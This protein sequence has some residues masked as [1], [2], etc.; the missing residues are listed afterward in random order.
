MGGQTQEGLSQNWL[1]PEA[2]IDFIEELHHIG[3]N[4]GMAEYI[5]AQ[6][7]LLM[8][9]ARGES[10]QEPQRAASLLGPLLCSSPAEQ[11][12]F[13]EH[14]ERWGQRRRT[15]LSSQPI[16]HE[17]TMAEALDETAK[18]GLRREWILFFGVVVALLFFSWLINNDNE[19]PVPTPIFTP[20]G[21]A[22]PPISDETKTLLEIAGMAILMLGGA[23]LI[24]AAIWRGNANQ[25]LQRRQGGGTADIK[26]IS[27]TVSDQALF[28]SLTFLSLARLFRQR[29][30]VVSRELNVVRTVEHSVEQGGW[31]NPIYDRLLIPP[32]Y[33]VLVDRRSRFDHLAEFVEEMVKRLE[34]HG[35][36]ITP[37]V[38]DGDP[39]LCFPLHGKDA[40]QSL[41]ELAARYEN[42]RLII[43]S[44]AQGLLN[45]VS[46]R[47][48]P[49]SRLFN[50][51][52]YRSVLTPESPANWGATEHELQ[53]EF[54]VLPGTADGLAAFMRIIQGQEKVGE[55]NAWADSAIPTI[56]Q[57]RPQRWIERDAP[58][59]SQIDSLLEEL[60]TYLSE[61]G[62][63]WF[64]ACAVYPELHWQ[65]TITLGQLLKDANGSP[66][67]EPNRMIGLARLPWFRYGTMPDWLRVRL[68]LD[69]PPDQEEEVRTVLEALL[70]TAVQGHGE[71]L[72]LEIAY[73][74]RDWTSR[75]A[76]PL[77][78]LLRREVLPDS[79]IQDHV[80]L[81]FMLQR[82]N[83]AVRVPETL[84]RQL[85]T[86]AGN[87]F[88]WK[89]M[90]QWT[91]TNLIAV[92]PMILTD[93]YFPF[94]A[95]F[96]AGQS[97]NSTE[98]LAIFLL[99]GGFLGSLLGFMQWLVL[100]RSW[101]LNGWPWIGATTIAFVAIRLSTYS[102]LQAGPLGV[103]QDAWFGLFS[104]SVLGLAHTSV[105]FWHRVIAS[106]RWLYTT[107]LVGLINFIWV[108][109][110]SIN[111]MTTISFSVVI[112]LGGGLVYS[113]ITGWTLLSLYR[114][115]TISET[116]SL[117]PTWVLAVSLGFSFGFLITAVTANLITSA[118]PNDIGIGFFEGVIWAFPFVLAQW[119]V[120]RNYR[121][122]KAKHWF[123]LTLILTIAG[124][125][126]LLQL[127]GSETPDSPSF[128]LVFT[129]VGIG[130]GIF[131][132]VAQ[133]IIWY[134]NGLQP[135]QLL[136]WLLCSTAGLAI[137]VGLFGW[138]ISSL[139]SF[140]DFVGVDITSGQVVILDLVIF[141]LLLP[142]SLYGLI[143]AL[144]L[145]PLLHEAV[146]HQST[147]KESATKM[148]R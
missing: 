57:E 58:P 139:Q 75:L 1:T 79:P 110:L 113:L 94:S 116:Y 18:R 123:W 108:L 65:I 102:L 53:R 130:M 32:E 6:D 143:T 26:Q 62:Y 61:D 17:E 67:L 72:D 127:I 24:W 100:R 23:S 8:L 76:R 146:R 42:M 117:R 43:F 46:G 30:Q 38:F 115:A 51:W 64:E 40:P 73:E 85:F 105:L 120:L 99:I 41:N 69:L 7:L 19:F 145:Q 37:Y 106:R 50:R 148:K 104:L 2:L 33:L 45:P 29:V 133:T 81:D 134:R 44:E 126:L 135:F 97:F 63:A 101:K 132:G 112:T 28:P 80:F 93:L 98:P 5:A 25:F 136:V 83:L 48:A 107:M 9:A 122:Q 11:D 125:F 74:R 3:F 59:A 131:I 20:T 77:L 22:V 137:M 121:F 49:W 89:I 55:I 52:I 13:P 71:S 60:K 47:L 56:L 92:I 68:L 54:T 39:R 118:S 103:R 35:V 84:R 119:F 82:L 87:R 36:F 91:G 34:T 138:L 15:S 140:F 21:T 14:F 129:Y 86:R 96:Q 147:S 10:L 95:N 4:I 124:F 31:L 88:G 16:A 27:L 109:A 144:P 12:A 128:E 70:V 66:L 142:A 114:T 90:L 111:N 141:I 78:R